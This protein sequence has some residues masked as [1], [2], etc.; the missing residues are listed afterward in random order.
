MTGKEIR[1]KFRTLF[2]LQKRHR[3][4]PR[5]NAFLLEPLEP[6]VML[7]AAPMTPAVMHAGHGG[8]VPQESAVICLVD[9]DADSRRFTH[10]ETV[11]SGAACRSESDWFAVHREFHGN[12]HANDLGNDD[13]RGC[14][15]PDDDR[16][17]DRSIDTFVTVVSSDS[18]T[19]Y[20]ASVTFTATVV[21]T[22]H[23]NGRP[24]GTVSFYDGETLLGTD[25]SATGRSGKASTF[26]ITISSLTAGSHSSI[27]AVFTGGASDHKSYNDSISG[28]ITQTVSQKKLTGVIRAE[29]KVYDGS[30][31]ATITR[32][33]SGV[34]AQDVGNVSLTGG[35]AAFSSA[36]AGAN[37][38]V[39][40]SGATLTGSASGNYSL[41]SVRSDKADIAKATVTIMGDGLNGS[42]Y[43]G[44]YD[45]QA[46]A[47]TATVRGL[48]GVVLGQLTSGTTH[49]NVGIYNDTVTYTDATGNYLNA[50]KT[51]K[52]YILK[53]SVTIT[54]DGLNG[55]GYFGTYDGQ[56][57]AATA[58]VTG[59]G[60]VVL[61]QL[62]SGTTHTNA[63][64]YSDTLTY[65]DMT[66]NYKDSIKTVKSYILKAS[67][68]IT[69]TGY[70]V[71]FDGA[72]HTAT[73]MVAGVNGEDL[74]AGLD[75]SSTTHSAVGT[76]LDTVTFTDVTGNYKF[77]VK[78]VSNRIR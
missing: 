6:R 3:H 9:T 31:E 35:T 38:T 37:K 45:G 71:I 8:H 72:A 2:G 62:V 61:G 7:S 28:N 5:A 49:T 60:G 74:S 57:H 67:V 30:T 14:I 59:V 34:L 76:Y 32:M 12:G 29:D 41:S 36:N 16:T 47:A 42:G 51:V 53:A 13:R 15:E 43:F 25:R 20:G 21:S 23:W 48:G 46:H 19:R 69:V 11:R 70:S 75:L 27:H 64:I 63:G 78:N 55:S 24:V 39:T 44:T 4:E 73:G 50:S 40:L 58:T 22:G 17:A 10:G 54:G 68:T 33:L 18:T 66:G 26:S 52:S 56:A 77:T 1:M 65:T